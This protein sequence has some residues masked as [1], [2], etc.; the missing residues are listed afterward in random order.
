[1]PGGLFP[2]AALCDTPCAENWWESQRAAGIL[3]QS[4]RGQR[5]WL[6]LGQALWLCLPGPG[7]PPVWF[8]S[9]LASLGGS[10]EPAPVCTPVPRFSCPLHPSPADF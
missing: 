5:W 7:C 4:H 1:M 8:E 10:G 9:G 2:E 3:G 6:W